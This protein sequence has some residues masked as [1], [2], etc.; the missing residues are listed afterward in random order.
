M[1]NDRNNAS[2]QDANKDNSRGNQDQSVDRNQK[3]GR[4]KQERDVQGGGGGSS[5]GGGGQKQNG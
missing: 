1:A 5:S 3:L 4:E 2:K